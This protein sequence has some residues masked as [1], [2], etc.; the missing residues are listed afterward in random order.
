MNE[1]GSLEDEL[2]PTESSSLM[3]HRAR[4]MDQENTGYVLNNDGSSPQRQQQNPDRSETTRVCIR[5]NILMSIAVTA[6]F[7]C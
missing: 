6:K 4:T 7:G 5:I 3:N 1:S 2:E